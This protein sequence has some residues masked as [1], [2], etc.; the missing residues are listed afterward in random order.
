MMAVGRAKVLVRM[1]VEAEIVSKTRTCRP[2]HASAKPGPADLA[3][4]TQIAMTRTVK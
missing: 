1:C 2:C 3:G 4:E